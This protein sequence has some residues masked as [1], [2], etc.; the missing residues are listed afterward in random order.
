M[1]VVG[2]L[3]GQSS[4]A[5]VRISAGK[6]DQI[7]LDG[8]GRFGA[9]ELPLVCPGFIDIQINGLEGIDFTDP[10]LS[11]EQVHAVTER[12]W[13]EGVALYCP[14]LTTNSLEILEGGMATIARAC[15]ERP[16]SRSILGIHLEG[17]YISPEDGPRGAHPLAHVRTPDWDEFQRLQ[18]AADGRI[19]LVTLAPELP[20]AIA[21]IKKLTARGVR[22]A[23][24]HTAAGAQDIQ[25]ATDAGACMSTHLG[26]GA[27]DRLQRHRNYLYA[28][29]A[30]DALWASFIVDGHHLPP[31][32]VKIFLRAKRPERTILV[33][34]A[35]KWAGMAPGVYSLE[36][37]QIQVRD[38]GWVG[39]VGQPWLAGS[40][41]LLRQGIENAIRFGGLS[42]S[43]AVES[44]TEHPAQMLG[45]VPRVGVIQ[46]GSD[47]NVTLATWD[48]KTQSLSIEQTIVGGEV[49][50]EAT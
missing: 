10:E 11:G 26:N 32:V 30:S 16:V 31:E 37:C 25:A 12:L 39:L 46:A 35:T 5:T 40:G 20:G 47:A 23:I 28:Q 6:I 22:V 49:V 18:H 21:F 41:L 9:T 2:V 7:E 48:Q 14:T 13:Q 36:H 43:E 33:S 34:D 17:P 19:C 27:H 29:L 44:V 42:V 1:N 50:F 4:V 24:G 45:C 3:P 15:R 38:D 8:A